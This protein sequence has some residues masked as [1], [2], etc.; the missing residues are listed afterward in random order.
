MK[1]KKCLITSFIALLMV[2]GLF[3]M[4]CRERDCVGDGRCYVDRSNKREGCGDESCIAYKDVYFVGNENRK[5][6]DCY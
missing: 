5:N 2:C 6:C 3:L 4:A 1:I